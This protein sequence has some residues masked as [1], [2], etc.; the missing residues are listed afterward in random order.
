MGLCLSESSTSVSL[1]R[2]L[3][4]SPSEERAW[5]EF[6][7]RYGR[8]LY[9]WCHRWSVPEIDAQDVVQNTL[10]ALVKQITTF[11]YDSNRSFRAWLKTIAHRCWLR[12]VE[13]RN[14]QTRA[15]GQN[16][17]QELLASTEAREDLE[18]RF[19]EAGR[20]DLY[21][22]TMERVRSR[23]EP[24][25]WLAFQLMALEGESG[26]NVATLL[27]MQIS[28]VYMARSR[29]QKLL[30]EELHNSEQTELDTEC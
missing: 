9:R 24:N 28:A 26:Q 25:T 12:M 10:L 1:L 2:R 19:D 16:A 6:V 7:E 8:V 29:V 3:S 23:V 18:N 5:N 20:T 15:L 27:N 14:R 11:E 22:S 17:S 30:R 4:T 21:E 13:E